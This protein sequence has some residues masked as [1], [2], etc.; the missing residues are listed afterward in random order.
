MV[1][2]ARALAGALATSTGQVSV[3]ATVALPVA[4]AAREGKRAL[5][6]EVTHD[7]G[8]ITESHQCTGEEPIWTDEKKTC[9]PAIRSLDHLFCMVQVEWEVVKPQMP[10]SKSSLSCVIGRSE[11]AKSD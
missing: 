1:A 8:F 6:E 4:P 7:K 11:E 5:Q 9:A 3:L 2:T 10:R